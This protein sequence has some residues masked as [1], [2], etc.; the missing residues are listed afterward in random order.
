[1]SSDWRCTSDTADCLIAL[2]SIPFIS[3][4]LLAPAEFQYGKQQFGTVY[5]RR[6]TYH[7]CLLVFPQ[8]LRFV[9]AS[10]RDSVIPF[11]SSAFVSWPHTVTSAITNNAI[12][13]AT[14]LKRKFSI[15]EI[16]NAGMANKFSML[17]FNEE[18]PRMLMRFHATT[19]VERKGGAA[20]K[21]IATSALAPLIDKLGNLSEHFWTC[22]IFA[23]MLAQSN[24][25]ELVLQCVLCLR[26]QGIQ[27]EISDG[28]NEHWSFSKVSA[29]FA[30]N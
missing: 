6:S 29:Y 7:S 19:V 12:A 11:I 30:C 23:F 14:S 16:L 15:P 17:S 20:S 2:M 3:Y 22:R 8:Q 13:K 25:A 4:D 9:V 27:L 18:W 10:C 5:A 26:R 28:R 1:M 24:A 21:S